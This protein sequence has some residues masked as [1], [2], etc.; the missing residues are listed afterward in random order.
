[1]DASPITDIYEY[2][3]VTDTLSTSGQP[4]EA[5]L[6]SLARE[7]FEVVVNLALHNDPRYSLRDEPGLVRALG[8]QYIHIPVAFDAPAETDL[9]AFFDAMQRYQGRKTL[10]HCAA[11]K[12][13]SAFW[14]LYQSIKRDEPADQAFALMRSIW[15]PTPV[16]SSFISSMLERYGAYAH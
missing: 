1:M 5:Q 3:P 2:R 15:K 12:R 9:L 8:I 11:N 7:G 16:W 14:G 13:A 10:V 6:A 4:T